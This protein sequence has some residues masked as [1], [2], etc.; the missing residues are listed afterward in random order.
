ML[1]IK[2]QNRKILIMSIS[3]ISFVIS[4]FIT[5][6]FYAKSIRILKGDDTTFTSEARRESIK[7]LYRYAFV[8]LFTIGPKVTYSFYQAMTGAVHPDL[9][10]GLFILFGLS[11]FANSMVYF[12]KRDGFGTTKDASINHD[13]STASEFSYYE[14]PDDIQFRISHGR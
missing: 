7:T 4:L 13:E 12:F 10:R 9:E 3:N 8:Q 11:G 1:E 6:F 14:D 2:E 5:L